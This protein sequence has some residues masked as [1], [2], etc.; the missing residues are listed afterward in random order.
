MKPQPCPICKASFVPTPVQR[1]HLGRG[2]QVVCSP[3]CQR[4]RNRKTALAW[5]HRYAQRRKRRIQWR[6][7][8]PLRTYPPQE[9][10]GE[11]K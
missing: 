9:A 3:D 6:R 10:T 2:H 5:Q 4:A 1:G 8:S 11:G 7:D